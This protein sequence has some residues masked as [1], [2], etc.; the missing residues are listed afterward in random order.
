MYVCETYGQV[1]TGDLN[2]VDNVALKHIMKF[3]SKFRIERYAA[4]DKGLNNLEED[5]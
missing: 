3:G 5:L 2:I 4:W 1:F